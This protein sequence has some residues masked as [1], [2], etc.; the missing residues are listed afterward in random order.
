MSK[1][2]PSASPFGIGIRVARVVA[3]LTEAEL[4]KRAGVGVNDVYSAER[5]WVVPGD[6]DL[7]AIARALTNTTAAIGQDR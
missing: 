3:G 4:A 2:H 6:E 7:R 5:G 1:Q